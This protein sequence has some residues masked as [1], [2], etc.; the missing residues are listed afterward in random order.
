MYPKIKK[1]IKDERTR[2]D[3]R[4]PFEKRRMTTDASNRPPITLKTPNITSLISFVVFGSSLLITIWKLY[5]LVPHKL[6]RGGLC[7]DWTLIGDDHIILQVELGKDINGGDINRKRQ[8]WRQE[9]KVK[10]RLEDANANT[11]S[12]VL[13]PWRLISHH[14]LS[15][16]HFGNYWADI[17]QLQDQDSLFHFH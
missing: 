10:E 2:C 15:P 16:L 11:T 3:R 12:V 13:R 8:G 14:H 7:Y 6:W 9:L 17:S 1:K 5:I 4:I